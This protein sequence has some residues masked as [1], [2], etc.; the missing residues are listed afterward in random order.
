M[1]APVQHRDEQLE[2]LEAHAGEA[3]GQHVRAQQHQRA[4]LGVAERRPDAR[5]VRAQQV[6]LQLAQAVERDLDV[7]EVAE[8]GRHAV[9][10]RAAG[11]GVVDHPP[12]RDDALAG[13]LGQRHGAA[14]P[15]HGLE[16]AEVERGAVDR[17]GPGGGGR[18]H[19]EGGSPAV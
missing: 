4:R 16:R 10:D 3:A 9:D 19:A 18:G 17:E 11:D 13:G 14:A 2:R 6:D 7:G 1:D 12:R 5:R 15:R 8:A